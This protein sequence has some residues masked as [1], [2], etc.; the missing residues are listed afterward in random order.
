[1]LPRVSWPA[2]S[3]VPK[4]LHLDFT[5]PN[6]TE[7]ER[8]RGRAEELGAVLLLDRTDE[9]GEPLCTFFA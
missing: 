3:G 9:A 4:Q 2:P 6:R 7:L 5:V 1:M 8:Q